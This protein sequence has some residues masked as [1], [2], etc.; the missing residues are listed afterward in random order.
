MLATQELAIA[1]RCGHEKGATHA[2]HF[3][4]EREAGLTHDEQC[5]PAGLIALAAPRVEQSPLPC[6]RLIDGGAVV[7]D[8][9]HAG[10]RPHGVEQLAAGG[11]TRRTPAA[12]VDREGNRERQKKQR[13]ERE[14]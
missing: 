14:Y 12:I 13:R 9:I 6:E 7:I 10:K 11:S 3:V 4:V 1:A 2:I 8:Q 5:S